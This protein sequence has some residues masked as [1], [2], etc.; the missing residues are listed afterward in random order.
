M[1]RL[2]LALGAILL[3]V[4]PA[5]TKAHP[6]ADAF[7]IIR[8]PGDGRVDVEIT[9]DAKA[10]ALALTGLS[11][12]SAPAP[13][14]GASATSSLARDRVQALAPDL[15]RLIELESDGIRVALTC[16]SVVDTR[17]RRGLV[18]VHLD[19]SLPARAR[20]IRWR[21]PFMLSAYPI[22]VA[23]G[24]SSVAPDNYDWLAGSERSR[25]YRLDALA[26]AERAW[27]SALRLVPTGFTHILPAGV[28]HVL[29]MLGLFLMAST[30]RALVLQVSAFTVAHSLTLA[31]GAF[32][33]VNV[34]PHIV[35]PLIAASIAFIALENL[36]VKSVTR[37]RLLVVFV[38][39]LLHG[40]GFAG[41][42]AGLG[43][44]G[45][46]LAASLVGFNVGVEL[47]Q[48]TVIATAALIVR[49]LRLS[50][51]SERQFVLR[52]VSAA[53]A[54]TGLFWAVERTIQ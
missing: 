36:F 11:T 3:L 18:T 40:L 24:S 47:G 43:L 44:S 4:L 30:R 35:E 13:A 48:L 20:T 34:P 10:L 31:L 15:L 1:K 29:F 8:V 50:I 7:V 12:G 27:Q 28:D 26:T 14:S 42:M 54:L 39:G 53:I 25:V 52:P 45:G 23:G 38:F 32:G 46:H 41:A 16:L 37:W 19:G 21:A 22:A 6:T 49:T 51:D 2:L 33:A 5:A 9:A 17:D